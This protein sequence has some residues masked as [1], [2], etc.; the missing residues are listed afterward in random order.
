MFCEFFLYFYREIRVAIQFTP[1]R[2]AR[3]T[4]PLLRNLP[5]FIRPARHLGITNIPRRH[6]NWRKTYTRVSN[7]RRWKARLVRK[8]PWMAATMDRD[9]PHP[10]HGTPVAARRIHI[11]GIDILPSRRWDV[12]G[13]AGRRIK[14]AA[15]MQKQ[16]MRITKWGNNSF[17]NGESASRGL[18]F[19]LSSSIRKISMERSPNL[20]FC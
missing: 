15:R 3:T 8:S 17:L 9:R 10:G 13:D 6:E 18:N 1:N 14:A 4:I 12:P 5:Y 19:S 2:T 20:G 11:S 16:A 7:P